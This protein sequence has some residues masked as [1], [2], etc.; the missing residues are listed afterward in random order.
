MIDSEF[1]DLLTW[2]TAE[3]ALAD[4]AAKEA[5][6]ATDGGTWTVAEEA[7]CE[8]CW[9][10]RTP[11]GSLVDTPDSRYVNHIARH[12]PASVLR[13]VDAHK[14]FIVAYRQAVHDMDQAKTGDATYSWLV[15]SNSHVSTLR[16]ALHVL[17][18]GWGWTDEA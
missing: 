3:L 12:D 4:S 5:A 6:E 16:K 10:I 18:V 14:E 15:E 8:C 7:G 1:E 11:G 9:H 17:A 13:M 2:F